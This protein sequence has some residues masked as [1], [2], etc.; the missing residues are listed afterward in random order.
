[1][2][3]T[4]LLSEIENVD[5]GVVSVSRS[6]HLAYVAWGKNCLPGLLLGDAGIWSPVVEHH[7]RSTSSIPSSTRKKEKKADFAFRGT[8]SIFMMYYYEYLEREPPPLTFKKKFFFSSFNCM[9]LT[10]RGF[11]KM[12]TGGWHIFNPSTQQPR[13]GR[14]LSARPACAPSKNKQIKIQMCKSI[15]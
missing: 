3:L 1:M 4:V 2:S 15:V 14:S 10:L 5:L 13:E 9:E 6:C 7:K 12:E 8:L 11:L